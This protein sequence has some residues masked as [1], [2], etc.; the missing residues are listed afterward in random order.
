M[1]EHNDKDQEGKSVVDPEDYIFEGFFDAVRELLPSAL[2]GDA[3]AE[4]TLRV[5]LRKTLNAIKKRLLDNSVD[6][7]ECLQDAWIKLHERGQ[8]FDTLQDLIDF[9]GSRAW[10]RRGEINKKLLK[11]PR[12]IS[13]SSLSDSND[14]DRSSSGA[15]SDFHQT[16]NWAIEKADEDWRKEALDKLKQVLPELPEQMR[17]L[18]TWKY[19][20]GL[21]AEEITAKTGLSERTVYRRLNE[22]R[23]EV[24]RRLEACI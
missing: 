5:E 9:L 14:D 24:R 23:D 8:C 15:L 18:L 21:S 11:R 2:E 12:H 10:F 7:R 17:Q 20:E 19:I 1:N 13:D 4:E 22:A 6:P 16:R 3:E